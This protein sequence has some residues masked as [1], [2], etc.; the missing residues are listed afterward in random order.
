MREGTWVMPLV[1]RF[2][3]DLLFAVGGESAPVAQSRILLTQGSAHSPFPCPCSDC[4]CWFDLARFLTEGIRDST[5]R[6]DGLLKSA[7]F[8]GAD[9]ASKS[10]YCLHLRPTLIAVCS[11]AP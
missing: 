1:E 6:N 8:R 7:V 5:P 11:L 2:P 9:L 3:F 4:D 10:L